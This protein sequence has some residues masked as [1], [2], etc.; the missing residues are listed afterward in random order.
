[1]STPTPFYIFY[2]CSIY[3]PSKFF[4]PQFFLPIFPISQMVAFATNLG[5]FG[6]F[7]CLSVES[8]V[9]YRDNLFS[10]KHFI[11]RK[12]LIFKKFVSLQ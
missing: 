9:F 8:V 6:L 1:M 7:F 4:L 2:I 11:W 3:L 12:C 10:M 5:D